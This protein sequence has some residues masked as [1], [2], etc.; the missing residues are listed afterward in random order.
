M[1]VISRRGLL[2]FGGVAGG[3]LLSGC[4][5]LAGNEKLKTII[6][7]AEAATERWQRL[8]G[9]DGLAPEFTLTDL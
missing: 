2:G 4:D 3:L 6:G 9:R 8:V 7:S 1:S 5:A